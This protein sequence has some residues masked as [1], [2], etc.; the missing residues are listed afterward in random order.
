MEKL[1][2]AYLDHE[3]NEEQKKKVLSHIERCDSCRLLFEQYQKVDEWTTEAVNYDPGEEYW[4]TYGHRLRQRME[5][6]SYRSIARDGIWAR[7]KKQLSVPRIRILAVSTPI[8]LVLL[9]GAWLYRQPPEVSQINDTA[10]SQSIQEKVTPQIVSPESPV[11]LS[12][13]ESEPINEESPNEYSVAEAVTRREQSGKTSVATNDTDYDAHWKDSDSAIVETDEKTA[14]VRPSSDSPAL[15]YSPEYKD[16]AVALRTQ[17]HDVVVSNGSAIREIVSDAQIDRSLRGALGSETGFFTGKSYT[18]SGPL[19]A[20]SSNRSHQPQM[21]LR[22]HFSIPDGLLDKVEIVEELFLSG[23]YNGQIEQGFVGESAA[24]SYGIFPPSIGQR[25][26]KGLSGI[27]S[28]VVFWELT[29]PNSFD[30]SGINGQPVQT[31]KQGNL[32]ERVQSIYKADDRDKIYQTALNYIS[33][34][35]EHLYRAADNIPIQTAIEMFPLA[36]EKS[37]EQWTFYD[38]FWDGEDQ[39]IWARLHTDI[40]PSTPALNSHRLGDYGTL[41]LEIDCKKFTVEKV[42]LSRSQVVV[43]E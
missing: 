39:A 21:K 35:G 10:R 22:N 38:L 29:L 37:G 1:L 15:R 40:L 41:W 34:N 19:K 11:A 26:L 32:V 36:N 23:P 12:E 8:L 6:G 18:D 28:T 14:G 27:D 43:W 16:G 4:N 25:T 20:G 9:I 42:L 31:D 30:L 7:I 2:G 3:L 13:K 24:I 33:E 17:E 5:S